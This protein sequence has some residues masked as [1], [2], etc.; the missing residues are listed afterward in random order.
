MLIVK[1]SKIVKKIEGNV[2]FFFK[3]K[4]RILIEHLVKK[5]YTFAKK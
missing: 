5:K 1:I 2:S 3:D 4:K